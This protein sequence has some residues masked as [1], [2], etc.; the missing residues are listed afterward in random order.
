MTETTFITVD[1]LIHETEKA[2]LYRIEGDKYWVP[3]SVIYSD[4][5]D[6]EIEIAIWFAKNEGW[7]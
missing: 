5:T 6:D 3:K 2:V 7:Y 4:I 1:E